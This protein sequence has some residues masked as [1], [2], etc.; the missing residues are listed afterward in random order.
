ME[1]KNIRRK[2]VSD[3]KWLRGGKGI[4]V[5]EVQGGSIVSAARRL[6]PAHPWQATLTTEGIVMAAGLVDGILPVVRTERGEEPLGG[7][8]T[9]PMPILKLSTSEVDEHNR[10]WIVLDVDFTSPEDGITVEKAEVKQTSSLEG[11][12]TK[13]I[14]PLVLLKLFRKTWSM[15]QIAHFNV[16]HW[17]RRQDAVGVTK[18]YFVSM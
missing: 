14:Y 7:T 6:R 5:A 12:E 2:T 10:S 17:Y 16:K 9:S 8:K 15:W 3:H 1:R 18:H 13:G 11:S 4:R